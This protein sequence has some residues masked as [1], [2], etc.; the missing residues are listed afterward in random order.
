MKKE[1]G[2]FLILGLLVLSM[3]FASAGWF[4]D[5]FGKITGNAVASTCQDGTSVK[6]VFRC[7]QYSVGGVTLNTDV[8]VCSG[9]AGECIACDGRSTGLTYCY[10]SDPSCAG[11]T[12]TSFNYS[13]WSTCV[14]GQQTRT[15]TSS[16]PS[17]CSGGSPV[18][19]QSCTISTPASTCTDSDG[20]LNYLVKGN[21]IVTVSY[22]NS[23]G[24]SLASDE[25]IVGG[26]HDGWLRE[27][28]CNANNASQMNDYLCPNGCSNGACANTTTPVQNATCTDSDGGLNYWV[29]GNT[30]FNY[31]GA[32]P[33]STYSDRCMIVSN[34]DS[35]IS[36]YSC[37]GS[38]CQVDEY[39]CNSENNL[40][41][42]EYACSN[43]CV[44]GA[45]VN[46]TTP[47]QNATCTDSD[48]GLNIH[49]RGI[50]TGD[51]SLFF[52][53]QYAPESVSDYC[54]QLQDGVWPWV[55]NSTYL[56]WN[57]TNDLSAL[58]MT[59][60]CESDCGVYEFFCGSNVVSGLDAQAIVCPGA[61]VDGA[62]VVGGG[63]GNNITIRGRLVDQL[64]GLPV[65]GA[66]II[67]AYEFWPL[68]VVTDSNGNFEFVVN[69]NFIIAEG[70]EAGIGDN[71][72]GWSFYKDCYDYAQFSLQKD[73][74]VW[75]NVLLYTLDMALI[76]Y[77]FDAE[78]II[79]NV[80]GKNI[81]DLGNLQIYPSADLN[82]KTDIPVSFN[83]MYK[84][85][86]LEGYNGAGNSNYLTEHYLSIAL[87]LDY[88]TFIRFQ[89]EQGNVYDSDNYH[90]PINAR[91]SVINLEYINRQSAWSMGE[92]REECSGCMQEGKCVSYGFRFDS[93]IEP[94][95]VSINYIDQNSVIIKIG[96]SIGEVTNNLLEGEKY[97]L[98]DG[99]I[100][101]IN[102]IFYSTNE[103][104]SSYVVLS[105]D[106][107]EMSIKEGDSQSTPSTIINAYCDING[108]IGQQK[109]SA[110]GEWAK[111]QNNYECFSNVCSN[112]EC[113]DT[114]ALA[115]E[116]KGFKGFLTR[117]LCRLSNPFSSD[118]YNSCL[119]E[120]I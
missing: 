104:I 43:G 69:D 57:G 11:P 75:D 24:S 39:G 56:S 87:P 6:G 18:L 54:L 64:N 8:C 97:T 30:T 12:C 10:K 78:Y 71:G 77:P 63:I 35:M 61:C 40:V 44:N 29:K 66:K 74:G 2:V 93:K 70:S 14:N 117:M 49:T 96:G 4:S 45:C 103:N 42:S 19:S 28:T 107:Y 113:V 23:G 22:S 76:K 31:L 114:A 83:V 1:F 67:S 17:G 26:D 60:A 25:C 80:S 59:Q 32:G 100:L 50:G 53:S 15:V 46:T 48:G 119:A 95:V 33:E 41:V 94:K 81:I 109:V 98:S 16:S 105:I 58:E 106:D 20:G 79:E 52:N 13:Y 92:A 90:V 72:A 38:N 73:Y 47:V 118:D 89:D 82:I 65:S 5:F 115:N 51:L 86:N 111:C 102:Q 62:C 9:N 110:G 21:V 85:K 27:L 112:G 36:N 88:E 116:L 120:N 37:S 68:E 91:C 55:Y 99:S 34:A 84:Y 101:K 108:Q 7:D 3:S